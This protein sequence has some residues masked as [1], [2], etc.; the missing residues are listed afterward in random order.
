M[1]SGGWGTTAASLL[2]VRGRAVHQR[3][4]PM[5]PATV[6]ALVEHQGAWWVADLLD[7]YRS[8]PDG[9]WRCAVRLNTGPGQ[10]YMLAVWAGDC[11][12]VDDPPPGWTD[13]R[14][15]G[16]TSTSPGTFSGAA[17]QVDEQ[18]W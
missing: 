1:M 2:P 4:I 12:P 5:R 18:P 17:T 6:H 16:P 10:T 15:N 3:E 9:R 8:G 7:Q 13:P 14:Q 11:R